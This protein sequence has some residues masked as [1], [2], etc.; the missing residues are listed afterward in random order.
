MKLFIL[1]TPRHRVLALAAAGLAT[2]VIGAAAVVSATADDDPSVPKLPVSDEAEVDPRPIG[3]FQ[4]WNPQ[5]GFYV[6]Q[7]DDRQM[8]EE[9]KAKD[10]VSNPAWPPFE[11]CMVAEGAPV[12][13]RSI[14]PL[15]QAAIS[16]F[17][18][19]LNQANPDQEANL[20]LLQTPPAQRGALA[21][22]GFSAVK[23]VA[24]LKC[25]D[26]WLTKSPKEVY[27]TTGVANEHYPGD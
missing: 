13:V 4:F 1:R 24:F 15:T 14:G 10:P 5:V 26:E 2:M 16:A 9:D 19:E 7:W 12:R 21:S 25:A 23:A 17:L 3:A 6:H 27:E 18:G 22:S 8:S 20:R 11:A